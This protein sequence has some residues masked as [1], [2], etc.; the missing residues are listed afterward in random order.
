MSII[1]NTFVVVEPKMRSQP[2]AG[3]PR[4]PAAVNRSVAALP[5]S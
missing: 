1:L 5:D 3:Q 2:E 4:K